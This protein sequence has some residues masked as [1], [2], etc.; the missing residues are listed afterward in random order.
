M[1][2]RSQYVAAVRYRC[3][4]TRL[5][6]MGGDAGP[7]AVQGYGA[8]RC[9]STRLVVMAPRSDAHSGPRWGV[10]QGLGSH[11]PAPTPSQPHIHSR[12]HISA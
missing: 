12:S 1:Q 7:L 9:D 10:L 2:P 5:V 4:N 6:M 3:D 11:C 8:Y